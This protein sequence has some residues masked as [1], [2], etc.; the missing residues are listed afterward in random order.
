MSQGLDSSG[1]SADVEFGKRLGQ[2][3]RG[4]PGLDVQQILNVASD[5]MGEHDSLLPALRVLATQPSLMALLRA[6]GT[7]AARPQF[8][9]VLAFARQ[10][11]APA[12]VVRLE[13]VLSAASGL[14]LSAEYADPLPVTLQGPKLPA[15]LQASPLPVTLQASP[16]PVTLQATPAPLASGLST[17]S[18]TVIASGCT[19][20]APEPG[21]VITSELRSVATP[22]SSMSAVSPPLPPSSASGVPGP[23]R[24]LVQPFLLVVLVL[25]GCYGLLRSPWM[26]ESFDLCSTSDN[27]KTDEDQLDVQPAAN[28]TDGPPAN[29]VGIPESKPAAAPAPPGAGPLTATP[30]RINQPLPDQSPAPKLPRPIPMPSPEDAGQSLW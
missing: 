22:A 27:Q 8:D 25:F 12:M 10:T 16:L 13:Q 18:G 19:P 4:R 23:L 9:A 29:P 11:L 30:P 14:P 26:C 1:F 7:P 2:A 20:L 17:G 24:S 3:L 6:A 5:L 15:T 21:T 28:A